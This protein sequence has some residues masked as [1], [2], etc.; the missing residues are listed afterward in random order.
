MKVTTKHAATCS[1][2]NL[3]TTC[4]P[5]SDVWKPAGNKAAATAA[6]RQLLAQRWRRICLFARCFLHLLRTGGRSSPKASTALPFEPPPPPHVALSSRKDGA[7]NKWRTWPCDG[8]VSLQLCEAQR[9]EEARRDRKRRHAGMPMQAAR[10]SKIDTLVRQWPLSGDGLRAAAAFRLQRLLSRDNNLCRLL[11]WPS[12]PA[13]RCAHIPDATRARYNNNVRWNASHEP[14]HK[15]RTH[16]ERN[17]AAVATTTCFE[18]PP[19]RSRNQS[20]Q[21]VTHLSGNVEL[22]LS[23]YTCTRLV[24]REL[25]RFAQCLCCANKKPADAQHQVQ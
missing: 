21:L 18:Q 17:A 14:H 8:G 15:R 16:K 3:Q 5:S 11:D 24:V 6:R 22:I 2:R 25:C 13:P 20:R 12:W 1:A 4:K 9:P 19:C 23:I 7:P 10:I